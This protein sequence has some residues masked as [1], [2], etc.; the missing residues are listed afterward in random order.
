M[1]QVQLL[2][3]ARRS[4]VLAAI[5]LSLSLAAAAQ[6]E[7]ID[8]TARGTSTQMSKQFS[9]KIIINQYSTPEERQT[10]ID[11]FKKGQSDG[12]AKQ[13]S[14]MKSDGQIQIPG[15]V[16]YGIAYVVSVPTAT[17][18]KVRFVTNRRITFGEAYNNT[19]SQAYDLTAGEIDINNQDPKKSE[20]VLLPAAQLT[21]NNEGMLQWELRQN[22]WKL[23]NI[24]DWTND[25]KK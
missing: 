17:G 9:V 16:G 6:T 15:T 18:R 7:T 12:L 11:A 14:K 2:R 22:P 23:T 25:K 5:A 13:L 10:L 21:M 3:N 1:T 4:A 20:G 24:I 8:A 19:Q